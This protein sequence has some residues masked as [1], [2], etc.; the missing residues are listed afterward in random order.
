MYPTR[1]TK[2][3]TRCE[4]INES[5][6]VGGRVRHF[7]AG[8]HCA[9][10]FLSNSVWD[11]AYIWTGSWDEVPTLVLSLQGLGGVYL[12]YFWSLINYKAWVIQIHVRTWMGWW[13]VV[14]ANLWVC[15]GLLPGKPVWRYRAQTRCGSEAWLEITGLLA[16]TER[17][18]L[19]AWN[20]Q[21]RPELCGLWSTNRS[22]KESTKL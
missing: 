19:R 14:E 3:N 7:I 6:Y 9:R 12:L 22:Q 16:C 21:Q 11:S 15:F 20:I 18:A 4:G 1:N 17:V 8:L 13:T 2:I 10:F 5:N